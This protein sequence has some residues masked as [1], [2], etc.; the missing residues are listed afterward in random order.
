MYSK[1]SK[2]GNINVRLGIQ[3]LMDAISLTR[4]LRKVDKFR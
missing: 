2:Y 4:M 1:N 3:R